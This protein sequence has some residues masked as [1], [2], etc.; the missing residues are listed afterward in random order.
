MR[1]HRVGVDQREVVV[2]DRERR[3]RRLVPGVEIHAEHVVMEEL[4]LGRERTQVVFA[5]S[6]HAEVQVHANVAFRRRPLLNQLTRDAST[7][8]AE[9]EHRVEGLGRQ[10]WIDERTGGI[11]EGRE[12]GR[13]NEFTHLERWVRQHRRQYMPFTGL[14]S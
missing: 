7:A 8:A 9:I 14:S 6:D 11:V 2:S 12:V 3:K 1:K 13:S 5:P 4:K 10:I